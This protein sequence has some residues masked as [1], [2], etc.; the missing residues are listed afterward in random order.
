M[1]AQPAGNI[2]GGCPPC[3]PAWRSALSLLTRLATIAAA[4]QTLEKESHHFQGALGRRAA[5]SKL[6]YRSYF[7]T[8]LRRWWVERVRRA[9]KVSICLS[10]RKR[11]APGWST[12][13][14]RLF[15]G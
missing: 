1:A 11:W 10:V 12:M 9:G 6:A 7:P 15:A 13:S 3:L 14:A 4:Q 2:A 5:A 8:V